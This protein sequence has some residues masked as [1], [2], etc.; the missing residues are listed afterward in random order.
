MASGGFVVFVAI[1]LVFYKWLGG[2]SLGFVAHSV[3]QGAVLAFAIVLPTF[4]LMSWAQR[5]WRRTR[6]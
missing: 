2:E 3:G 5:R 6:W 1:V 4:V